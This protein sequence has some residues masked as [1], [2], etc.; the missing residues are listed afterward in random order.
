MLLPSPAAACNS[1]PNKLNQQAF[2]EHVYIKPLPTYS[3]TRIGLETD[4]SRA[5]AESKCNDGTVPPAPLVASE[6]IP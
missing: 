6:A 5:V 4:V 3:R 2:Q 1:K